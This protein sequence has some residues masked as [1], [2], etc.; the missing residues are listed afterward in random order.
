M[1]PFLSGAL[2]A[3][4]AGALACLL[5]GP[6]LPWAQARP[7]F[8]PRHLVHPPRQVES[9]MNPLDQI[10]GWLAQPS[11]PM[12]TVRSSA[13]DNLRLAVLDRFDGTRW[14][15]TERYGDLPAQIPCPAGQAVPTAS[16]RT[17]VTLQGLPGAWLPAQDRPTSVSG[18]DARV[19]TA[20]AAL[21]RPP[22]SDGPATYLVES[23]VPR[24]TAA[25]LVSATPAANDAARW[26]PAGLPPQLAQ[27]ARSAT[28]P[29]AV[30]FQQMVL[31]E[32]WLRSHHQFDR[33]AAPGHSYAS[34]AYF[35]GTSKRGTSE[36]FATAF[37]VMARSLGFPTRVVVGFTP[38]EDA[39]P[40]QRFLVRSGDALAWPEVEFAGTGWVPFYPTPSIPHG[41]SRP[42]PLAGGQSAVRSAIDEKAVLTKVAPKVDD[43]AGPPNRSSSH[44]PRW[45]RLLVLVGVGVI[46]LTFMVV[47]AGVVQV[48]L[49]TRRRRTAARSHVR[50]LGAWR[51]ATEHVAALTHPPTRAMT[52]EEIAALPT[53]LLPNDDAARF[54]ALAGIFNQSQFAAGAVTSAHAD[55]A[56]RYADELTCA[57]R[58]L[59]SWRQRLRLAVSRSVLRV[60]RSFG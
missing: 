9:G 26:L 47:A 22:S 10:A 49:R 8:D 30:P 7:P 14:T 54:W 15:A 53:G 38:A 56:W 17:S 48:R 51:E 33:S 4:T 43:T 60:S 35:L 1:N 12:F 44:G 50:V 27:D 31:L 20:S 39:R 5:V 42:G 46:A 6:Q 21:M 34:L 32:R 16:V 23:R 41:A 19:A 2:G 29:A 13:P 55:A 11:V 18:I 58:A 45:Q 25:A 28:G 3:L 36:Q 59:L 52:A 40:G 37:A 24:Y 57:V